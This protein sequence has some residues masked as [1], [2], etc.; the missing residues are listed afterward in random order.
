M[1]GKLNFVLF[2]WPGLVSCFLFQD[3]VTSMF[4][5]VDV[6]KR[7]INALY[8]FVVPELW[9]KNTQY[10]CNDIATDGKRFGERNPDSKEA[11]LARERLDEVKTSISK[12]KIALV[13]CCSMH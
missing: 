5:V 12:F 4:R 1:Q 6:A 8:S 11:T 9:D 2:I 3:C 13:L 10:T 7:G